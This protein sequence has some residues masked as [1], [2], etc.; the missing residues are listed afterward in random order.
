MFLFND[1]GHTMGGR[2]GMILALT[3]PQ[4]IDKL[5]CV[6][7]TPKN[8]ESSV[9]RWRQ[10]REACSTLK[11]MEAKLRQQNG[12]Q[13]GLMADKVSKLRPI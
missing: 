6:D 7:A 2:I 4:L 1:A 10:L 12:V 8:T 11:A 5:V 13:R 3:Q 9:T